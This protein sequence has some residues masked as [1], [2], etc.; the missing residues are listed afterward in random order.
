MTKEEDY[1]ILLDENQILSE[2]VY[3]LEQRVSD[4]QQDPRA[5]LAAYIASKVPCN[6]KDGIDFDSWQRE[7][8]ESVEKRAAAVRGFAFRNSMDHIVKKDPDF[9]QVPFIYYDFSSGDVVYTPSILDLFDVKKEELTNGRLGLKELIGYVE[10]DKRE[11]VIEALKQG[12]VLKNYNLI[13]ATYPPKDLVLTSYPLVY[14]ASPNNLQPIG[15]GLFIY[16]P[17]NQGFDDKIGLKFGASVRREIK[18]LGKG[19]EVTRR[20]N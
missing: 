20:R 12:Q 15:V 18:K 19:F 7:I 3:E 6:K 10:K 17:K 1:R 8:I 9:K 14:Q 11:E 2:R 4:L 13:T 5:A 16:D